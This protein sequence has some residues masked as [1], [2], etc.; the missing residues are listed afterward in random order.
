MRARYV[1]IG[2]LSAVLL[3]GACGGSSDDS[4][5]ST[6]STAAKETTTSTTKA[7]SS[8]SGGATTANGEVP[9]PCTLVSEGQLAADL[10]A[11][12][13]TGTPQTVDPK[14]RK[15]CRYDSGL[16]LA[17]EVAGNYDASVQG[18]RD[19]SGGATITEL[20]GVGNAAIWQDN[21]SGMGQLVAQGDTYM[22]GVT[23]PQGGQAPALTI[24]KE[25]LE[26]LTA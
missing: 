15:I 13:G 8:S 24:A 14:Q 10:G 20:P 1:V 5:S 11:S 17:V 7:A 25:M 9:D 26:A 16:I 3:L 18:I 6:S 23:V 19:N 4:S 12:P 2:G 21:G 22:V